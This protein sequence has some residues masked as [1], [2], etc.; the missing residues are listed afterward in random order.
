[1]GVHIQHSFFIHYTWILKLHT[2]HDSVNSSAINTCIKGHKFTYLLFTYKSSL[3]APY[4]T[5][6]SPI[7]KP[8]FCF[9]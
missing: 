2:C 7:I 4:H 9:C 1:M 8:N 3:L 5:D 6:N